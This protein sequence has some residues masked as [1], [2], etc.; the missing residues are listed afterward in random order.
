LFIDYYLSQVS[1]H[2]R[3]NPL[4]LYGNPNILNESK[5]RRSIKSHIFISFFP[6]FSLLS[7]PQAILLNFLSLSHIWLCVTLFSLIISC[8]PFILTL[9]L[10]H[11]IIIDWLKFTSTSFS[12]FFISLFYLFISKLLYL[13]N[14][15]LSKFMIYLIKKIFMVFEYVFKYKYGNNKEGRECEKQKE[16]NSMLRFFFRLNLSNSFFASFNIFYLTKKNQPFQFFLILL[17]KNQNDVVF[18]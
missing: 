1:R 7:M 18:P 4:V 11:S 9:L 10:L 5:S 17:K 15:M 12:S 6:P 8:A 2:K 16:R 13:Q 3:P 14:M